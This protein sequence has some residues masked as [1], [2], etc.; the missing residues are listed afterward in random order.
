MPIYWGCAQHLLIGLTLMHRE[1]FRFWWNMFWLLLETV[2]NRSTSGCQLSTVITPSVRITEIVL[3]R[4]INYHPK[5]VWFV[6]LLGPLVQFLKKIHCHI[7]THKAVIFLLALWSFISSIWLFVQHMLVCVS[8]ILSSSQGSL[9]PCSLLPSPFPPLGSTCWS[10][11]QAHNPRLA[12][13]SW[14]SYLSAQ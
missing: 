14:Q 5:R 4:F 6:K 10:W 1:S 9:G 11:Y 7:W 8:E 12:L 2:C 3:W 13:K